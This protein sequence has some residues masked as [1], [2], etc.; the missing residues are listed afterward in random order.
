MMLSFCGMSFSLP[1]TDVSPA[2][3]VAVPEKLLEGWAAALFMQ[4][5]KIRR[6]STVFKVL[7]LPTK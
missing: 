7:D 6:L 2:V 1:A 3:S 5:A 4:A